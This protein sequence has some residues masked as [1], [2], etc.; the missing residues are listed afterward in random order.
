M[1]KYII[2]IFLFLFIILGIIG[3]KINEFLTL[4]S[5][6]KE[7]AAN[8]EILNIKEDT[9]KYSLNV[10]YPKCEYAK[11][12]EAINITINEYVDNL[13]SELLNLNKEKKYTL[14][15]TFETYT[16]KD[17]IS[18]LFNVSEN[19]GCLHDEKYVICINYCKKADKILQISD[20]VLKSENMLQKLQE[21]CY[22]SLMQNEQIKD[23]LVENFVLEGTMAK[24]ENYEKFIIDNENIIFYFGEYQVVPYYLGIQKVVVPTY[25]LYK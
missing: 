10:Y 25:E 2:F 11:L 1:K 9:D 16:S 4:P 19:L 17:T 18:F 21:I 23:A 20:L 7:D 6:K 8:F 24:I 15:I 5:V 3:I 12:N 22:N 13:K 14:E